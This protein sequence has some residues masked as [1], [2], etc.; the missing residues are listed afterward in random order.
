MYAC[1]RTNY[2][3]IK[4]SPLSNLRHDIRQVWLTILCSKH[5]LDTFTHSTCA[6]YGTN[7]FNEKS[8]HIMKYSSAVKIVRLW[9]DY[10]R[11]SVNTAITNFRIPEFQRLN[12]ILN[13]I[14]KD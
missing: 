14:I 9:W 10:A 13:V 2:D 7:S 12:I 5:A 8:K 3:N 6:I 4:H 11:A 1:L